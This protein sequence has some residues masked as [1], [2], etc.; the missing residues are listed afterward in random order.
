MWTTKEKDA[1][2]KSLGHLIRQGR[3]PGKLEC[4]RCKAQAKDILNDR[5]WTAN[6][7]YVKNQISK[8]KT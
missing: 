8:R 5:E 7:Y 2:F 4:E 1:V 3:L 6:K